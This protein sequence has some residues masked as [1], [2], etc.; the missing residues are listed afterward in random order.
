MTTEQTPS[1]QPAGLDLPPI[2]VIAQ[3][4]GAFWSLTYR[5]PCTWCGHYHYHG[6]GRAE[7]PP[8][9]IIGSWVSHCTADGTPTMVNLEIV[10]IVPR[11][12]LQDEAPRKR[13][14]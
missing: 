8:L 7:E 3:Y 12:S 9:G 1:D 2:P 4:R 13:D 6:S 5:D 11:A 10:E 14:A